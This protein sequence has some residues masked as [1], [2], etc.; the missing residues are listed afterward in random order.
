MN[1]QIF[2]DIFNIKFNVARNS[3]VIV[4]SL[5]IIHLMMAIIILSLINTT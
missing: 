5:N 4:I 3:R 1:A 2:K